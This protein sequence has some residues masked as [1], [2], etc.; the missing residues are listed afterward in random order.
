[1]P[2]IRIENLTKIFGEPAEP[3]LELLEQGLD[4]KEIL[5]RTGLTLGIADVS[6]D[7][8]QG[9]IVV[10]MGLSGCGKSTLIRCIN[11]LIEPTTGCVEIDGQDIA[12]LDAESVLKLRRSKFGMVF[13]NFA[14][15]P[16]RT[17]LEN[18]AFG[19]EVRNMDPAERDN[20]ANESLR[21]VG[22][23]GWE[24]AYPAQLSGG[25]Q[26]RVGLARA[27]AVD[28]DILLMDEAFS[29][30]DPLIRR[31]M[32]HE[33]IELQSQV[34]KTIVFITHDLDEAL[35]LG[36]R[37]VLMKD[38]YVVQVGTPEEILASPAN[39]YVERFVED[40]DKSQV[41]TAG[42]VMRDAGAVGFRH[43][44][45]RT[46]LHRMEKL[47]YSSLLVLNRDNTLAGYVLAEDAAAAIR[48]GDQD[49]ND[50]LKTDGPRVGPDEPLT[51][52]I[53]LLADT[54]IPVAVISESGRLLGTV[55]KS[56]VLSALA[57]AKAGEHDTPT[58]PDESPEAP[59][60]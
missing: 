26:Q 19:L 60:A 29:A 2:K 4:R 31:D 53:N 34:K 6:F 27:L 33:L 59:A 42:T 39:R 43:D 11:R 52:L 7:V 56:N 40:V 24:Q 41:L 13:Q 15:F 16:H 37:I 38:G 8:E 54:R 49:I 3:A 48:R 12:R 55:V 58:V 28:P 23:E 30:L 47:S 44:G 57:D 18:V 46:L 32:Q 36:D 14:L 17:I 50:I 45:P 5:K 35:K 9:E 10:V 25:M 22:L 1:M 51:G 20:R 21:Q